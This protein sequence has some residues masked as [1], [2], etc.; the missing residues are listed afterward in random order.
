MSAYIFSEPTPSTAASGLTHSGRGGAGNIRPS[1]VQTSS[2]SSTSRPVKAVSR[3][4]R[5]YT[6]IGGAG[7]VH[8]ASE[9]KAMTFEEDFNR[10]KARESLSVAHC[11]IGGAGNVY[12]RPSAV[13]NTGSDSDSEARRESEGSFWGRLSVSSFSR[14]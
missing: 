9:R 14:R 1:A 11:G 5:F 4:G 8:A 6:G 13:S 12:R 2:S 7:N 3:S 10:A